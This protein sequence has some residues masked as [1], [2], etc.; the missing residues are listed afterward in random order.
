MAASKKRP[1]WSSLPPSVR[2]E[3]ERL[4]TGSVVNAL[5]CPGG[6]S[7]GFASRL[8]LADGRRVF[9]KA[10]DVET[11]PSQATHYRTE[12]QVA[13][14]LPNTVPAPRLLGS[15]D[16]GHWVILAF[17]DLDGTDPPS[18]GISPN[19]TESSLRLASCRRH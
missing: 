13:A 18:R 8:K 14:S 5:S 9:V 10:M 7:P 3:I 2:A 19:S 1:S 4:V 6:F 11:W 12:R 16:D 15:F 17:E